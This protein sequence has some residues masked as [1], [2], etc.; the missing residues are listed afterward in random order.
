MAFFYSWEGYSHGVLKQ[1]RIDHIITSSNISNAIK[2][3]YLDP[4][5]PFSD[6]AP[7]IL[8]FDI[9][10]VNKGPGYYRLSSLCLIDDNY[11][12]LIINEIK[13]QYG[14]YNADPA[15]RLAFANGD[16]RIINNF[17]NTPIHILETMQLNIDDQV[18]LEMIINAC[19][20]SC[21]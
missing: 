5:V 21:L 12:F 6:H 10:K 15:T 17:L 1:S 13:R 3:A 14:I 8:Q 4:I 18:F 19:R 9:S 2:Q 16:L 11:K 20:N 7:A